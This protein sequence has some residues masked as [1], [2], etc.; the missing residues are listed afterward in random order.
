MRSSQHEFYRHGS[1]VTIDDE[2][3]GDCGGSNGYGC[4]LVA[5][6]FDYSDNG[7]WDLFLKFPH[8]GK[9]SDKTTTL[10]L[11]FLPWIEI[12]GLKNEFPLKLTFIGGNYKVTMQIFF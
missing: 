3:N 1:H 8:G 6:L 7:L 2:D 5:L 12:K 4:G 10:G 11:A 9:L